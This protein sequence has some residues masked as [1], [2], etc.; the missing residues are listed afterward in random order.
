MND[1]RRREIFLQI[2]T[3]LPRE[4]PGDFAST[5]RALELASSRRP[6]G[7]PV[8]RVLDVACGPGMQTLHL[9]GLMPQARILA[10]DLHMPYLRELDRRCAR[11]G[12]GGRVTPVRADMRRLPVAPGSVDLIWCEGGAYIMGVSEA[13]SAWRVLLRPGGAVAFTDAVWLRSDPPEAVR[14]LWTEYP[15]M[16]DRE[17]IRRRV[18]GAGFELIGDF[19]LPP[20]AWWDD[21][22]GPMEQRLTV[23]REGYAG[24]P[25]ALAV[26]EAE[27]REIDV[28]RRYGDNYGYAFFVAS[29]ER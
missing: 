23:L 7:A 20:S 18:R 5:R 16:A 28:Y 2:H 22:Y 9:A 3:G 8:R 6:R 21:Y 12:A 19:V 4:A 10:V 1:D 26:L 27:G 29:F 15:A 11:A 13:L 24:D 25:E 17:G 14:A